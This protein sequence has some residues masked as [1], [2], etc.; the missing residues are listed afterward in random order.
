MLVSSAN[1]VGVAFCIRELGK[2]LIY[3][4]NKSGRREMLIFC[5]PLLCQHS[6]AGTEE[7][8]KNLSHNS[9]ISE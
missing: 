5:I 9:Q 7:N 3:N 6:S 4:M 2:S 8:Y 1:I